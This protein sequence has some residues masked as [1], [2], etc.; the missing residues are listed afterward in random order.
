MHSPF[1]CFLCI[2]LVLFSV[3]SRQLVA[4]DIAISPLPKKV[5]FAK[6]VFPILQSAC[7]ECHGNKKQEGG[8]RLDQPLA[9]FQSQ[10]IVPGDTE[11]SELLRRV[12]LPRGADEAMPAIGQPLSKK[13]VETLRRWIA[14]GADWPQGFVAASHWSYVL[15][16]R[17]ELPSVSEINASELWQ[18]SPIDYFVLKRLHEDGL[19]PSPEAVPEKLVRRLFLDIIGLPPTPSEV[20]SFVAE[21]TEK[22][23]AEL[24]DDLLRR[25]QFGERWARPWL[26]LARYADSHGFQRDD[27][28]DLWAYRD[29]VIQALNDDMPFD[30]FSIEQIA[31][32]LLPNRTESQKI[33]TGFH[34]CS[35]TNCEAG[36]LPEETRIEQVIERVNTTGTVWLGTTL[37]CCQCHDHKYDPFSMKEYYQLLAFF[38]NTEVEADLTDPKS[39]SSIQFKGPTMQ[40]AN[41]VRDA[42]RSMVQL[43]KNSVEEQLSQRR[44]ALDANLSE[45]ALEFEKAQ[46]DAARSHILDIVDFQSTGTTDSFK[47]LADG[48]VLLVGDD[49]PETDIYRIRVRAQLKD[50]SAVRLEALRHDSLPG[51]GPGRGDPKRRN[52]IL[53]DFTADLV[54]GDQTRRIKF[55]SAKASFSQSKWDVGG[56]IDHQATT[57]WAISPE[58]DR[59]HWATFFFSQPLEI[60][61][62]CELMFTLTQQYGQART[63]G[64]LRLTALTGN[65]LKESVSGDLVTIAAKP[66]SQWSEVEREKLLRY[67]IEQ[68]DASTRLQKELARLREQMASLAADTTLLMVEMESSRTSTILLRGDYKQPGD[69]VDASVPTVLHAMPD[70]PANRLTLAKWLVSKQNPLVARVT[71]NRWWAELFGA[72]IVPTV[73]D[74]GIK[75]DAPTHPDLLDWLAVELMENGWS[76]KHI[77]KTIVLSATYRQSSRI[78]PDLLERDDRNR[79]LARGP[80]FRMD[81][82]MVRD[83]ALAISGLLDLGQFGPS[84]RPYQ[85]DGIWTKVGGQRY[86]YEVSSGSERYRRGI[87]VVLK[88]GAPYPS[89]INFDAT[90]RL[91]CT[92]KRSR[93]NT[94]LQALTLLN[95]PVHVEAA[96]ALA[97]RIQNDTLNELTDKKVD[98]AFQLCL[99]RRPTDSER[100]TL[101][102]L[103]E[104]Q[105][106][107]KNVD[108]A[109][110]SVATTLLNL[111]ET[112][113]KD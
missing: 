52:F 56:A 59:P 81:A 54:C 21:P 11:K 93:T 99:A 109:W 2:C 71:V 61:D 78:T 95:D 6:D 33:A 10:A 104:D 67:R 90:A 84:I 20:E 75:G 103:L 68:D 55:H 97:A 30:Q 3:F 40:L 37:E 113:T 79:L 14:E 69:T 36:S 76:M 50:V 102:K 8:L 4:Q 35:P 7:L 86:E 19:N 18:K 98:Y 91:T 29:W 108:D 83:N 43:Q 42:K 58:F 112:I 23:F 51:Q 15:P 26:D 105:S 73:D 96:K 107:A 45:W 32:D 41:T 62:E 70:G 5:N 39:P 65:V 66:S 94:P 49:P 111:H 22:R 47:K 64:C 63:I 87:Y 46:G 53:S 92:V 110:F 60:H 25:P 57:G 72:G 106:V 89:F 38:N 16:Q 13:E 28:R 101:K 34:R 80:R 1:S 100:S 77:L 88:R 9:A 74:F 27:F 85:P 31:G 44:Q 48:S 82:E 17:P 24:V 12:S